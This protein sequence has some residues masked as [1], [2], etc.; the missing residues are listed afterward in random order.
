MSLLD[1]VFIGIGSTVGA[2]IFA[3]FGQAGTIAGTAVWVSFL[4]GG[5]IALFQAYS[6]A[7]FG[8]RFPSSGGQVSWI[9]LSFGDGLFTGGTVVLL[10]FTM[11]TMSALVA[12]SFG[13]YAAGL[14]FG[15]Q[16]PQI[17]VNIFASAI[18]I[19][20]TIVNIIGAQ[21]V[22]KV[23]AVIVNVVLVVL[24]AFAIAMLFNI[25]ISL[26]SPASYPPLGSIVASVALTY[27]AYL[28][29]GTIAFTGGDL[30]DPSRN[31]PRAMYITVCFVALLY[32]ALSLGV[33][34]I[35]PVE[36]VIAQANT[37]LAAAAAPIF[38]D[39][40]YTLI[41]VAALFATAGAVNTQLYSSI[42]ATFTMAKEGFLPPR[43]SEE[44]KRGGTQ[45]LIITAV[46]SLVL[47]NLLN[48]SAI[49]S[50]S[51]SVALGGYVLITVGHLRLT[52][53]THASKLVL[54]LA[55]AV[56]LATLIIY[57]IYTLQTDPR[58]FF[59]L[60][61][62]IVL[63]WVVEVIWRRISHRRLRS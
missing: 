30:E 41:S 23:Q 31:M 20:L 9:I 4:I 28:G 53:Q 60:I 16:A 10:Y 15:S 7:K 27:F 17:W 61:A 49:A 40:G 59:V 52:E 43:F 13:S 8:S 3:L 19:L 5:I 25:D 39:A 14:M 46:V 22:S 38:G 37:A 18:I 12:S 21:A 55:L 63:A 29:F 48:I 2:G 35:L 54:Y 44:R 1:A 11:L 57:L 45:G 47:V 50:L 58:A 24:V 36:E 56:T 6:F 33:F 51:S 34:G 32:I 62:F 26:L 42:G